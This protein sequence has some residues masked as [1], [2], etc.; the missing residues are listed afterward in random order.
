MLMHLVSCALKVI[1][2]SFVV[3]CWFEI[4]MMNPNNAEKEW[5]RFQNIN[6]T[7]SYLNSEFSFQ[8]LVECIKLS[9]TPTKSHR[10]VRASGLFLL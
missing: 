2:S 9:V 4:N 10:C 6:L 8:R 1:A 5:V 3:F 7:I